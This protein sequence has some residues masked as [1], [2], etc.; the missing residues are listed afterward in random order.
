MV[1]GPRRSIYFQ[2][3]GLQDSGTADKRHFHRNQPLL[4]TSLSP[5]YIS[6]LTALT[7]FPP[8]H[9]LP[10]KD[11]NRY[12]KIRASE[13]R[14]SRSVDFS[15]LALSPP[16]K[17]PRPQIS[18]IPNKMGESLPE[19]KQRGEEEEGGM[20]EEDA[21]ERFGAI[22]S[23]SC[24]VSSTTSASQRFGGEKNP[25]QQSY[26]VQTWALKKAFSLRRSSSVSEGYCR[27]HDQWGALSPPPPCDD[28]DDMQA[29]SART[30]TT[31]KKK[32]RGSFLKACKRLF[33]FSLV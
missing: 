27:I 15:D 7:S 23:R 24:S 17:I 4:E 5:P 13:R 32:K 21:G 28:G 9:P 11:M 12:S 16:P 25:Q 10:N 20:A 29:R 6:N 14:Q 3:P 31:K 19:E 22:L 18:Q 2:G 8:G 26:G 33:G 30:T 1:K